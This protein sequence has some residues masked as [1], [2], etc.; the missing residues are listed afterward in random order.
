[1]AQTKRCPNHRHRIRWDIIHT[2]FLRRTCEFFKNRESSIL[3]PLLVRVFAF[4]ISPNIGILFTFY[5]VRWLTGSTR[6]PFSNL[7]FLYYFLNKQTSCR[8]ARH[9]PR[10]RCAMYDVIR[11]S[12]VARRWPIWVLCCRRWC[13]VWVEILQR[14]THTHIHSHTPTLISPPR[15]TYL[16]VE[17]RWIAFIGTASSESNLFHTSWRGD[18]LICV[19]DDDDAW[20]LT[21]GS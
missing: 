19:V 16:I 10:W 21:D 9:V 12:V 6:R 20:R 5:A 3:S 2:R 14:H 4:C 7:F 17:S 11:V 15:N 1:M 8:C 13:W 18:Y